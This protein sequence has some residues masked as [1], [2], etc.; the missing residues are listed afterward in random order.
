MAKPDYPYPLRSPMMPE[1]EVEELPKRLRALMDFYK[2]EDPWILV[3]K[4]ARDNLEGFQ[5]H[6]AKKTRGAPAR[7]QTSDAFII[8]QMLDHIRDRGMKIRP[9]SRELA[10]KWPELGSAEYIRQRYMLLNKAGSAQ[11]RA[12]EVI[13]ALINIEHNG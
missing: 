6:E 12:D 8:V 2:T 7:K 3:Y 1:Q 10:K 9:A 11:S 5:T 4:L 13:R